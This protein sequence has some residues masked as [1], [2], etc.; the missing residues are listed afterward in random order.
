[1]KIRTLIAA[2]TAAAAPVI[3]IASPA[4]AAP[5]QYP[6]GVGVCIS[7][8]ATDPSIVGAD[9]LGQVIEGFAGPGQPGSGVPAAHEG[10]RGDGPGGCGAPP[11]PHQSVR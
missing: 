7:Q 6:H 10:V 5:P 1:M 3:A 8:V 9:R 2:A 4:S 11:G